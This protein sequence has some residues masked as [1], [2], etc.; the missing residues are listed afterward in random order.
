MQ[1]HLN[2]YR[3]GHGHRQCFVCDNIEE[4][5]RIG[6]SRKCPCAST[7]SNFLR[8]GEKD[9]WEF[10][11]KAQ[12]RHLGR[13]ASVDLPE[14][15]PDVGAHQASDAA[16]AIRHGK[17][18]LLPDLLRPG[19]TV[20]HQSSSEMDR[21]VEASTTASDPTWSSPTVTSWRRRHDDQSYVAVT[22]PP[23]EA[24]REAAPQTQKERLQSRKAHLSNRQSEG[25][26]W[27][28]YIQTDK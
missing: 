4:R 27:S 26:R 3:C 1:G 2:S 11:L 22:A 9:R 24:L 5:R 13:A 10:G 12:S 15:D 16:P 14:W 28:H 25:N 21:E 8:F 20:R 19:W 17:K 7:I 23:T 6:L 18:L